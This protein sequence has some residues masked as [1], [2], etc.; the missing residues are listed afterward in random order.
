M[1]AAVKSIYYA[2]RKIFENFGESYD[3]EAIHII[4]SDLHLW[5]I[6]INFHPQLENFHVN[7]LLKLKL[8]TI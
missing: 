7:R 2:C 6:Q 4:L 5:L 3:S 1:L 8:K